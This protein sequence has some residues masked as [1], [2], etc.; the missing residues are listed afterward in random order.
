MYWS[1]VIDSRVCDEG[2]SN[3]IGVSSM[4]KIF[5]SGYCIRCL[6]AI[7]KRWNCRILFS[8]SSGRRWA[9]VLFI[10][11]LMEWR[12]FQFWCHPREALGSYASSFAFR[13]NINLLTAIPKTTQ[14][15][16]FNS[17][18]KIYKIEQAECK[19]CFWLRKIATNQNYWFPRVSWNVILCK[20]RSQ[21][22]SC[23]TN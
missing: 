18:W 2:S 3:H 9:R 1:L 17:L 20:Q 7:T 8:K 4:L 13:R 14:A 23:V 22:K 10:R 12:R 6:A 11:R 5:T 15:I 16:T 19:L 21:S